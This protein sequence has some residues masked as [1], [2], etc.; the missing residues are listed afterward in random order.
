MKNSSIF[1]SLSA[2]VGEKILQF[3]NFIFQSASIDKMPPPDWVN[4]LEAAT[5]IIIEEYLA[6]I[7]TEKKIPYLTDISQG[8]QAIET[9]K[10]WKSLFLIVFNKD[11]LS[12]TCFFPKTM[13]VLNKIPPINTAFFSIL[14]PGAI[15]KP[16]TG[17]YKG[18]LRCH[19]PI[20]LPEETNACAL[21]SNGITYHWQHEKCLI[22]DDTL[23]HE[24]YNHSHQRRTVLLIDFERPFYSPFSQLNNLI[25]KVITKSPYIQHLLRNLEKQ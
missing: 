2:F 16:H 15:I 11:V 18:L 10:K 7:S 17:L 20:E 5:P 3:V 21:V 8:Q 14:E 19:L 12:N 13:I 4:D 22:F 6:F 9:N 1:Y 23:M 24:A 25:L